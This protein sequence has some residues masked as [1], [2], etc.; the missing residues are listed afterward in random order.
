MRSML[1]LLLLLV[2]ACHWE[3]PTEPCADPSEDS[4]VLPDCPPPVK[5]V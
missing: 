3:T 4:I 2:A 5:Q 1:L